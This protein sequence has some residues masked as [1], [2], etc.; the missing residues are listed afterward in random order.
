MINNIEETKNDDYKENISDNSSKNIESVNITELLNS[1]ILYRTVSTPIDTIVSRLESGYYLIPDYQREYVWEDKQ[2]VGLVVSLLK[3]IPIPSV[4]SYNDPST[5][6]YTII[7][8]QQR[9]TSIYFFVKGIFPYKTRKSRYDFKK[10]GEILNAYYE[11]DEEVRKD[12][13]KEYNDKLKGMDLQFYDFFLTGEVNERTNKLLN[14]SKFG[15]NDKLE[16]DNKTFDIGVVSVQNNDKEKDKENTTLEVYTHIFRLLNSAGTPLSSQEIRNGIYY[17]SNLYRE[18]LK[19]NNENKQWFVLKKQIKETRQQNTEYLLRL[20]ALEEAISLNNI[21]DVTDYLMEKFNSSKEI[22]DESTDNK[23]LFKLIE[24]E[25]Y[26]TYNKLIDDFSNNNKNKG[27]EEI[28][29]F[30]K[31]LEFFINGIHSNHNNSSISWLN[32]EPF[33]VATSKLGLLNE[34]F[35]ISYELISKEIISKGK[36]SSKTEILKRIL[37]A[38]RIL[39]EVQDE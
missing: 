13:T 38:M 24:L 37:Q 21:E 10:I 3:N 39:L 36:T 17:N 23:E 11:L 35:S 33:F 20:L 8:G 31:K 22:A 9:L 12:K 28:E 19:F 16:F 14:Y 5:G 32:M 1:N 18:I 26:S 4:Y 7:D 29:M 25:K 27:K 15:L 34:T 6:R 30:I 2:V